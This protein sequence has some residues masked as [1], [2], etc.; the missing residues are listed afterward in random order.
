ME[1]N[2]SVW[3]NSEKLAAEEQAAEKGIKALG[4]G[5]VPLQAAVAWCLLGGLYE[6]NSQ[7]CP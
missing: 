5:Q 2:E 7:N 1:T 4:N 3:V 6:R